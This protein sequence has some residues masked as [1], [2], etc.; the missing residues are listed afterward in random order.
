MLVGK[1]FWSG[2]VD[3]LQQR[4]VAEGMIDQADLDLFIVTDDVDEAIAHI[5]RV[6]ERFTE[7]NTADSKARVDD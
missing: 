7:T 5:V 4:L 6:H 2:L 3:W 1:Q